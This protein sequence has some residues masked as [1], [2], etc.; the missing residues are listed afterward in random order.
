MEQKKIENLNKTAFKSGSSY[1]L[2]N[3]LISASSIITA[4]LFTRLLTTADYG[5][6][7]NFAAWL[8][9]GLVIIGLGLPYSI[10]NAKTDFPEQL[11]KYLASIQTLGSIVAVIV[12]MIVFIF[13]SQVSSLMGLDQDL[14]LVIFCY[15]LFFPSVTYAQEMYKFILK[16]K[17]NIY[18]SIFGTL[19]AIL[20]CLILILYVFNEQR[21]YGRVLGLIVPMFIMG[22]FFYIKIIRNGWSSD[23]RKYWKYALKISL[24]MIPHALAMVVLTQ[25]DRIMIIKLCGNS[26]AGLYSFGYSYAI[27]LTIFSNA[28]LQAYQPWLYINYK[29]NTLEPIRK[30]NN[31]IAL[32]MCLLTIIIITIAP[33]VMMILGAKNFWE[34][35]WV[36]M[37]IAIGTL[38]QYMY[39]TYTGLELYHK[40]TIIIAIGTIFAAILNY[41][42]NSMFIPIFGYIAAAYAT[43]FSYF[44]LALFHLFAHKKVTKKK[45]YDD[46]FIWLI[47]IVTTLICFLIIKLYDFILIRYLVL[48]LFIMGVGYLQRKNVKIVY[49]LLIKN[50]IKKQ[51]LVL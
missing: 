22:V 32:G 45:V 25:I 5:I 30:T 34:A 21:F 2:S 39:N 17:Q 42:L 48:I 1:M 26:D 16:Y 11:N 14:V 20:S 18:I 44:A 7:S 37:P 29:N 31:L 47:A 23:I 41:F 3:I 46:K 38:Y 51:E 12:L 19:G 8:N 40:K 24:P 49:D 50:F 27:L 10:G 9:I 6:A 35:K 4:P 36:V 28:V 13:K 15:L 33:E 43:F